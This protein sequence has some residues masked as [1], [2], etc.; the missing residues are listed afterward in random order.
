LVYSL[1]RFYV[2]IFL[3]IGDPLEIAT[4][5][6]SG[7]HFLENR[8]ENSI[9]LHNA[10]KGVTIN[11][12]KKFPF[13]STLKR[14]SVIAQIDFNNGSGSISSMYAFVKGAPEVLSEYLRFIPKHYKAT[15]FY[16][17]SKGKRGHFNEISYNKYNFYL[18]ACNGI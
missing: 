15:Y 17:M 6:S 12:I 10:E 13:S 18:S 11:V 3:I 14:M 4:I 7:Y 8:Q 9:V 1:L 5:E 16:H 2:L